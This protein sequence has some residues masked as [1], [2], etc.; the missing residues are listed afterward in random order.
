MN[1]S[2]PQY[3]FVETDDF[4]GLLKTGVVVP[5]FKWTGRKIPR[6]LWDEVLRFFVANHVKNHSE[7]VARVYY[8]RDSDE[9]WHFVVH[10]QKVTT[11]TAKDTLA[12][13]LL[14]PLLVNGYEAFGSIHSHSTMSAFQSG[15]DRSDEQYGN[16]IHITLGNL[17]RDILSADLRWSFRGDFFPVDLTDLF[18]VPCF[19][20]H[21]DNDRYRDLFMEFYFERVW[22]TVPSDA[23]T[24]ETLARLKPQV[25]RVMKDVEVTNWATRWVNHHVGDRSTPPCPDAI[26]DPDP[27]DD[28]SIP[29]TESESD[30]YSQYW[31]AFVDALT[32]WQH[33][34]VPD[35]SDD[36]LELLAVSY[37]VYEM[38][39]AKYSL[40]SDPVLDKLVS[41]WKAST[42]KDALLE[43]LPEY[44]VVR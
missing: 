29:E 28:L 27:T 18:D 40:E 43:C 13:E 20:M 1:N 42:D 16:G 19:A 37:L 33:A 39:L 14:G 3:S 32:P 24:P 36:R 11:A 41:E 25:D 12:D 10:P 38:F 35:M 22:C 21:D 34:K 9:P 8:N 31:E 17:D 23:R 6:S 7:A 15:T 2:I 30:E 44:V 5:T 26:P 4:S